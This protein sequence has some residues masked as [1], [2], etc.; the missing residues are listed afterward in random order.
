MSAALVLDDLRIEAQGTAA[1]ASMRLGGGERLELRRHGAARS[2][3]AGD[4]TPFLALATMLAA[5]QG[6]D[7]ELRSTA[8]A[9]ALANARAMANLLARWFGWRAPR[10]ECDASC[11]AGEAASGVGL[12]F[13]RGLDSMTT[14]IEQRERITALIGMDWQDPPYATAGTAEIWEA[15]C[16]AARELGLPLIHV[17]SNARRFLDPVVPWELCHGVLL[18]AFAQLCAPSIG[19]ALVS[20]THPAGAERAYGSHPLLDP[21]WSSSRVRVTYVPGPGGR[22][23]KAALVA[24]DELAMRRLKV[25]WERAGDGNCGRCAKCLLTLTNFHIAGRLDAAAPHFDA[26]LSAA[27]VRACA[28][29]ARIGTENVGSLLRQLDP[30]DPLHEP[31]TLVLRTAQS[32]DPAFAARLSRSS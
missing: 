24:G 10:L 9:L 15:T 20:G 23:E 8:D 3:V 27:A 30:G 12:F 14:L 7:L 6:R 31:W 11:D 29:T 2:Q 5:A 26:P 13:S 1:V 25:C 4:A 18:G 22:S 28:A 17:S 32:H 21:L 19:E 16:A